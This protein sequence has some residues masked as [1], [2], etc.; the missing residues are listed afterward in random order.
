MLD[1]AATFGSEFDADRLAAA[2][3]A[4]LLDVLECLEAADAA[5]LVVAPVRIGVGSRSCTPCSVPTGTRALSLRRRLELHARAAAALAT[6]LDD[7]RVQSERARHA[8][9]A[10]PLGDARE[11]IELVAAPPGT[12]STAY[13]YD[14]AIAHYR[15]GLDAARLL[16]PPDAAVTLDLTVR[17]AAALHHRGDGRACRCCS[18][19]RGGR[20]DV[21]DTEA[22]VR[23]AAGD[24]AVRRRRVRRPDARG[25]GDHGS[26]AGR[27]R[28]RNRARRVPAC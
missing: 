28:D 26:R 23:A 5:G 1:Q 11:A 9:L 14:E 27:A 4:P 16:D 8:C 20:R 3:G 7:D 10:L 12:P 17:I 13:A 2:H 19:R 24:P 18:T 25:T 21:G 22:L 15:R 6:P